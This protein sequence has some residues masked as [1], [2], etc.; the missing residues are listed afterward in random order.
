M[1]F[2]GNWRVRKGDIKSTNHLIIIDPRISKKVRNKDTKWIP[3]PLA[4][5]ILRERGNVIDYEIPITGNLNDPNFNFWDVISDLLKNIFIKPVTTP[6][7]MEVKSVE[8]KLEKS[9]TMKWEMQKNILN[10]SQKKFIYK[11]IDFLKE[12]PNAYIHITPK[13]YTIKEK[14]Y[15]LLYEAKKKYFLANN[16]LTENNF[17]ADD[18]SKIQRMSIKEDGFIQYLKAQVKESYLFTVQEKAA[19][20]ISQSIIDEQFERLT[21]SRYNSF[22]SLFKEEKVDNR[23][24]FMQRQNIVPFNGFSYYEIKYE[25]KFPEYL[26]DAYNKMNDFNEEPPRLQYQSKR[27]NVKRVQ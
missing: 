11:M 4:M 25:G 13:H 21:K 24:K 3:V 18:S 1:E 14:E 12:N 2:V 7:R 22:L 20:L 16:K 27:K 15:I 17:S 8:Q 23:V 5:A 10:N 6:Y 9:L 19:L 26:K